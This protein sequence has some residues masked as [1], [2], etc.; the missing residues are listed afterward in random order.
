MSMRSSAILALAGLAS[1]QVGTLLAPTYDINFPNTSAAENPLN[2]LGANGP[3]AP[4]PNVYGIPYDVPENCTVEQAFYVSRHGS[5]YPDPGAYAGW[6]DM[7]ERFAVKNGYTASGSLSFLQSWKPVLTAPGLQMS[8]LSPTGQKEI[9]DMA[10]ALRT[11]YPALYSEGDELHVWANNYSRVVQTARLF[12]TGFL[13]VNATS[14]GNVV[15]VTST[16]STDAIGNSLAPSDACPNFVDVSGGAYATNWTNVYVPPI[17]KRLQ[18]LISGNLTLTSSDVSQM[19]YLCGFESQ[20]TG[21]VSPWCNV[22]TN[23]ELQ[24]YQYSNDLRYYY[25]VGPGTDL[26]ATMMLPFLNA[27]VGLLAKGPSQKG[28]AADGNAFQ[29]PDLLVSFLNDGQL[30]E[31]ITASG[32]HDAQAALSASSMDPNRLYIG[33]RFTTMRGQVAFERLNCAVKPL[34][35]TDVSPLLPL[36]QRTSGSTCTR[37]QQ[38]SQSTTNNTFVR[39][40]LNDVVYPIPS[41]QNGPGY[42]CLLDDYA[43]YVGNKYKKSGSWTSNCNVTTAGAPSVVK[44]STF[45][46]DL[47]SDFLKVIS[48]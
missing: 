33:N 38:F 11:R 16:G 13:G 42:S 41:C 23:E 37:R 22:F 19:P 32:V 34:D 8:N 27:V 48:P 9:F 29:V 43:A 2:W 1:G 15:V 40:T 30:N 10:Y 7:Q 24:H 45:Y 5:R 36:A 25:G 14:L 3:Y 26:P 39:V 21:K 17:Q 6:V 28:T 20:I 46:T 31:L 12:T 4:G 35:N 47:T 44:G 18:A